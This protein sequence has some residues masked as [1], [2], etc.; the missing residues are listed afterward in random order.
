MNIPSTNN[1][2]NNPTTT[3]EVAAMSTPTTTNTIMKWHY[4]D[5][6]WQCSIEEYKEMYTE[7]IRFAVCEKMSD[8]YKLEFALP[9]FAMYRRILAKV[10]AEDFV[11]GRRWSVEKAVSLGKTVLRGNVEKIFGTCD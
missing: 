8:M 2:N 11:A 9:K 1:N 6:F 3:K 10:L 5:V 7:G 4:E